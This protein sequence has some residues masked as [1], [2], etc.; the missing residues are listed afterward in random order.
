MEADR[1]RDEQPASLGGFVRQARERAG[2]SVRGL[3]SECGVAASNITR[4]E[5]GTHSNPSPDLLKRIANVLDLDLAE[6]FA[7]LGIHIPRVAPAL[8]TY[9]RQIYPG[10]P[11]DALREAEQAVMRI[12]E[13]YGEDRR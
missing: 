5:N 12:A 10:L 1:T 7:Y 11:D 9:L 8:N 3:A 13:R 2:I 4:L 6:L